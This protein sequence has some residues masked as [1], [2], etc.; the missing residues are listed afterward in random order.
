M[1]GI[2]VGG[3]AALAILVSFRVAAAAQLPLV[4][5]VVVWGLLWGFAGYALFLFI[6]HY[7][8]LDTYQER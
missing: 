1:A 2:V 8:K 6:Q 7:K 5:K 4:T 3:Y